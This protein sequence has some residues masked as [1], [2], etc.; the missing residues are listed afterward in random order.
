MGEVSGNKT[1]RWMAVPAALGLCILLFIPPAD[2]PAPATPPGH[3][4]LWKQD[5]RWEALEERFVEARAAGC[6]SLGPAIDS[7]LA[8]SRFLTGVIEAAPLSPRDSLFPVLEKNLFALGPVI[9]ACPRRAPEY[10]DLLTRVRAVLKKQSEHWDLSSRDTRATL[11]RLLYG[12]RTAAE[13][14]LLQ[15]EPGAIP[16]LVRGTDEPSRT[17]GGE[18]LGI[19]VHSG[20][21]LVSRGGA[22]TSALIARGSDFPGNFSHVA[23]LHCDSTTGRVS[24]IESHIEKG[25]AVAGIDDYL[26][27]TKLRIMVLRLRADLPAMAADPLMPHRA[28]SGMLARAREHHIPYDFAMD[29]RDSSRLFCSEVVSQAYRRVGIILWMGM[30]RISSPGVASWL[31]A[32][33]VR[34]FETQEPSDLE[35]DPQLRV[36]AEWRDPSALWKDHVDNAVTDAMLERAEEGERLEYDRLM[37]GPARLTKAY[38]MILNWWG[39]IGPMPEGMDAAAG[40]RHKRFSRRHEEVQALVREGAEQFR[41]TRGYVPPYWEL[42]KI[43]R[44]AVG[45]LPP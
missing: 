2:P 10:L 30:S 27:D 6:V 31:A 40:L 41:R 38:S 42:L 9:G 32:F 14:V 29:Y 8:V 25:V 36:V 5:E 26:R 17:P 23:L 18:L 1:L 3:P 11:Y 12:G 24:V 7:G 21:I 39:A 35:Y 22:P 28:A 44:R 45:S 15:A 33:G 37:L 4:F 16:A 34:H 19:R 20:D 13:E 43:A